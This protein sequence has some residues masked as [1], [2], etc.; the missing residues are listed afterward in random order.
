[1]KV[2]FKFTLIILGLLRLSVSSTVATTFTYQYTFD[3]SLVV[4]G[5]L[6]GVQNGD[7]VENVSN[8]SMYFNGNRISGNIFTAVY[9]GSG[10][11]NGSI[12]SFNALQN[13]FLFINDDLVNGAYNYN[14]LFYM[15]NSSV[16]P[17]DVADAHS[18]QIGY[19]G[20]D[21]P[22]QAA[23][24]SLKA[25]PVSEIA[26]PVP[27]NSPSALTLLMAI[28]GLAYFRWKR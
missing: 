4:G 6:D 28:V 13:N 26:V 21:N 12:V 15:L 23:N 10:W 24:W 9:S 2:A 16:F 19:Y 1:M 8:V 22:T 18:T 17:Y 7:F 20:A 27:D 5:T 3:N 25:V 11:S 14:S